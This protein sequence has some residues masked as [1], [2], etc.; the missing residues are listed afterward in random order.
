LD[1]KV[2]EVHP[3]GRYGIGIAFSDSHN[4]GIYKFEPLRAACEC[5]ECVSKKGASTESFSV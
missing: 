3:V 4:T 5:P 2:S 1:I